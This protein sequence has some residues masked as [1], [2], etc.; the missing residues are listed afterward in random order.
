MPS[1]EDRIITVPNLL[2]ASRLLAV[3]VF[4]WAIVSRQ[5]ALAL[6]LL[7]YAGVSDW[8]DGKLARRLNQFSKL[9]E[10]LDPLADRL[11]IGTTLIGLAIVGII[12]WW[13]VLAVVARDVVML[14]YLAWLRTRGIFGVPV[15]Y[16]GKAATTMLLYSFPL[17]M[18]GE[19]VPALHDVA[20]AFGWAFGIW[21][22]GT[23]WYAAV[24]Y[25]LEREE[26]EP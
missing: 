19:A 22:L 10:T 15:H 25:W 4:L 14:L 1:S 11:Y 6:I 18:L 12:P 13:L 7:V 26:V 8:A 20:R 16:V 21:G 17:L 24:L 2:S 5:Y 3:P 9:G 23:Y